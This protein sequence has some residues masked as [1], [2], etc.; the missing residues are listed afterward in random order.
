MIYFLQDEFVEETALQMSADKQGSQ[1]IEAIT[2]KGLQPTICR[3]S[4]TGNL[5]LTYGYSAHSSQNIISGKMSMAA[6]KV[7]LNF[8]QPIA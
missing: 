4:P 2:L 8:V 1:I 5:L 6:R 7:N 3:S